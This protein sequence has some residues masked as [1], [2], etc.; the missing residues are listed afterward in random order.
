M[1]TTT[2]SPLTLHALSDLKSPNSLKAGILL[3][4]LHIPYN[5]T[6]WDHSS[7][8]SGVLGHVYKAINPVGRVPALQDPNTGVVVW[9]SGAIIDYLIRTYD[10]DLVYG[11]G[12]TA[13]EKVDFV[14]WNLLLLT[15]I[16]VTTG[17]LHWSRSNAVKGNDG[18]GLEVAV[19]HF[20]DLLKSYYGLLDDRLRMTRETG[21]WVQRKGWSSSD[22][23]YLP[24]MAMGPLLGF[25]FDKFPNIQA[26]LKACEAKAEVGEATKQIAAG[27][28]M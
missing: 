14:Q 25:S 15:G 23:H 12:P 13:Q 19:R 5:V 1:S 9:E 27:K 3:S 28:K 4:A 24:W 10:H 11:P 7:S 6:L 18:G 20:E 8:D 16:S 26:W 22:M 17:N 2:I 21:G